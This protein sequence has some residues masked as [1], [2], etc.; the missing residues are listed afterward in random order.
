MFLKYRI[1][2]VDILKI[3]MWLFDG[4]GHNFDRIKRGGHLNLD[5]LAACLHYK[6][7][8]LCNQ[9]LLQFVKDSFEL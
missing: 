9:L 4:A 5:I 7:L 3:C 2:I 8:S 1:H 6:V